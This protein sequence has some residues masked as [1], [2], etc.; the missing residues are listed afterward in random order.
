MRQ[1]RERAVA[2]NILSIAL[3]RRSEAGISSTEP[4]E[5]CP[6]KYAAA[7]FIKDR[8]T[9]VTRSFSVCRFKK[10]HAEPGGSLT[11]SGGSDRDLPEFLLRRLRGKRRTV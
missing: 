9:S 7:A 5:C 11:R 1:R 6:G 4:A 10:P 3:D 2:F 8:V